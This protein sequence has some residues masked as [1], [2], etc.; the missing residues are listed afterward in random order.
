MSYKTV[1]GERGCRARRGWY[2]KRV[3]LSPGSTMEVII[4][5]HLLSVQLE[6][7]I[8][9]NSKV[10]LL[11]TTPYASCSECVLR[12]LDQ[13]MKHTSTRLEFITRSSLTH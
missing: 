8:G 11:L 12:L 10:L 9:I 7:V 4:V 2:A 1:A 5:I 6:Q 3:G 13:H